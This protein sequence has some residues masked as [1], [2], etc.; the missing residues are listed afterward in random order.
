[1]QTLSKFGYI[2][3]P[4]VFK[5]AKQPEPPKLPF[6]FPKECRL[7]VQNG[8]KIG[9][10]IQKLFK[11]FTSPFKK[12]PCRSHLLPTALLIRQSHGRNGSSGNS[13]KELS[14]QWLRMDVQIRHEQHQIFP[15]GWGSHR[16]IHRRWGQL[17]SALHMCKG[18]RGWCTPPGNDPVR[19][20]HPS[21]SISRGWEL[22]PLSSNFWSLAPPWKI[23]N[24]S[25]GRLKLLKFWWKLLK[26]KYFLVFLAIFHYF[27]TFTT[28]F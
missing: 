10:A 6:C 18:V 24:C 27:L 5:Q 16:C 28:Q 7:V 8:V 1:M 23:Q 15:D 2:L 9:S 25:S 20:P 21:L 17:R 19:Y 12:T 14:F 11:N 4:P 26:S 22:G 3:W 13:A